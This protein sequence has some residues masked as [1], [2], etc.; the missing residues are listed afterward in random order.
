[1][2]VVLAAVL[3]SVAG[4]AHADLDSDSRLNELCNN[5]DIK[6]V[7]VCKQVIAEQ[8]DA[9]YMWGEEN[10]HLVKKQKVAK[11]KQFEDSEP[12]MNLCTQA[13]NKDRCEKLRGYLIEEYKAGIGL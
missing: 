4:L 10:A 3:L 6:N 8:L 13:P 1:M 12:M 7:L 11:L 2:K 9:A 5:K